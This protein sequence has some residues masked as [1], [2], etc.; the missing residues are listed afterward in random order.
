MVKVGGKRSEVGEMPFFLILLQ[1]HLVWVAEGARWEGDG[2]VEVT[3][4]QLLDSLWPYM[5]FFSCLI[6]QHEFNLYSITY[7]G[8][9]NDPEKVDMII[10]PIV[11]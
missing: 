5:G 1:L 10:P 4:R 2:K 11:T 9:D 6:W 7:N 8:G 3:L